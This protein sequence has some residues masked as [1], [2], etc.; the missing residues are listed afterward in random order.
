MPV[1]SYDKEDLFSLIGKKL[2]DEELERLLNSLK[3][4]VEEIDEEEVRVEHCPDRPDLFPIEGLARALRFRLGMENYKEISIGKPRLQVRVKDVRSRPYIACAVIRGVRIDDRYLKSLM[5]VQEA[6][7]ETLGRRREKVAIGI[8]DLDKVVPP[9]EYR[10]GKRNES[11]IPLGEKEELTLEAV[12]EQTQKGRAYAHLVREEF[13]VYVDSLGIFSFPP[14]LNSERT[15]VTTR[16]KNLFV[17]LTGTDFR[18][19]NQVLVLLATSLIE[20]GGKLEGVEILTKKGKVVTPVLEAREM[21]LSISACNTLL[22][23]NLSSREI[24]NL[25]KRMG[26]G[27]RKVEKNFVTL[28]VPPYRTDIFHE[29]DLIEDVAIAYGYENFVPELPNLATIGGELELER[30]SSRLRELAIGLGYQEV[31]LPVLSS[32]ERQKKFAPTKKLVT[33]A[34]PVSTLYDCLRVSLLPGMLNF[35]A[36]NKHVELPQRIFELGDAVLVDEREETRTKNVRKLALVICDSNVGYEVIASDV[37]AI[38]SSLGVEYHLLPY[39]DPNYIR[40]RCAE[41]CVKGTRIGIMGE[42]NPSLL[43]DYEIWVPVVMAELDVTELR[44]KVMQT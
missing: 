39:D 43:E 35:L 27:I 30:F 41:I 6:F 37:D 4:E 24:A 32:K 14:I 15:R 42:V 26:Y 20:R 31:M 5:Q 19:V 33:I 17:E 1:L 21:K 23:L 18:S 38:L 44:S 12:L 13:P 28:R 9:I 40:G 29:V 25:L 16:T 10:C 34:N 8:H 7:H 36:L 11:F 3:P 2:S 22:G